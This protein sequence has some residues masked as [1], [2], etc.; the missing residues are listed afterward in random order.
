[1]PGWSSSAQD[2][3]GSGS[4]WIGIGSDSVRFGSDRDRIGK[5]SDR[6][7]S[8]SDRDRI[9]PDSVRFKTF[10]PKN[11]RPELKVRTEALLIGRSLIVIH[12]FASPFGGGPN[13][14]VLCDGNFPLPHI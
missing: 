12:I 13:G 4:D 9:G 6:I 14:C 2:N 11:G 5:G 3:I 7:G 1:M 8:G 10:S